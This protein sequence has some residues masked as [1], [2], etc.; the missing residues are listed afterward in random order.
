MA[1]AVSSPVKWNVFQCASVWAAWFCILLFILMGLD[2]QKARK[3]K[4]R[5]PEKTLFIFALLGDALG[6]WI[7]MIV[8]HHK[9]KHWYFK[10]FFPL[11]AVLW[12]AGLFCLGITS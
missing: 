10:I 12:A 4:Y 5:I 1:A 6:G 9:T 2:K 11:I 7:G 8:F 3:G